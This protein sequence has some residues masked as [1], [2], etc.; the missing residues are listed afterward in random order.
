VKTVL[1]L[2]FTAGMF[3]APLARGCGVCVEDRMA[4]TYDHELVKRALDRGH[5]VVFTDVSGPELERAQ[6]QA[7]TRAVQSVRGVMRGSVR[8]SKAPMALSFEIDPKTTAAPVAITAVNRLIST[9]PVRVSL[10]RTLSD[11][12]VALR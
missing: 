10:I 2:L 9:Q 11:K 4:A 8:I 3:G 7:L 6:W 1:L 5:E 12:H